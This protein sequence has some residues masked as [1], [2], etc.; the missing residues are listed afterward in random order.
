VG[1]ER[2]R[3][4]VGVKGF[5]VIFLFVHWG[6]REHSH[7]VRHR[8]GLFRTELWAVDAEEFVPFLHCTASKESDQESRERQRPLHSLN[9]ANFDGVA[10]VVSDLIGKAMRTPHHTLKSLTVINA[11][12][13][14]QR[15]IVS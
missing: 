3:D 6:E 12:R 14:W 4:L 8:T 7:H 9:G 11:L 5:A 10:D 13:R 15:I 2:Q 1:E